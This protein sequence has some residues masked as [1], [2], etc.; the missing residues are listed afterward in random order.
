MTYLKAP[1]IHDFILLYAPILLNGGLPE[2]YYQH[3]L[4]LAYGTRL[5]LKTK[6]HNEEIN[7]AEKL[8]HLSASEFEN[9]YTEKKI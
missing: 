2:K 6:I 8:L 3:F 1:E 9:L 7:L 4:L 5:L